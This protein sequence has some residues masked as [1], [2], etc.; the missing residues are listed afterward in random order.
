[1]ANCWIK[2]DVL[3]TEAAGKVCRQVHGVK[4]VVQ[5]T[6]QDVPELVA[7]MANT[8]MAAEFDGLTEST[9]A[10]ALRR[11]LRAE[12]DAAAVDEIVDMVWAGESDE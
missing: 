9:R 12:D 10:S 7:L 1:M 6:H 5:N 11:W 8:S 2:G 4:P 3:S